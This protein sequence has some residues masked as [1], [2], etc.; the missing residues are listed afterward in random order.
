MTTKAAQLQR[1]KKLRQ[2]NALMTKPTVQPQQGPP[3]TPPQAAAVL[4]LVRIQ[5]GLALEAF[6]LET[7]YQL[8]EVGE[9]L[10]LVGKQMD[11][12]AKAFMQAQQSR[13][14][15]ATAMPAAPPA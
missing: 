8:K 11:E 1:F 4:S 5:N 14:I 7:T 9:F 3:L 15:P 2:R 10:K 13:I 12:F 6:Q